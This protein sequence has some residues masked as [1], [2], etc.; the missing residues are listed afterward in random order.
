[1]QPLETTAPPLRPRGEKVVI[2]ASRAPQ[3]IGGVYLPDTAQKR[4]TEGVIVALPTNAANDLAIGQ[5]V[6]FL[7]WTGYFIGYEGE[8][9][10][11]VDQHDVLAI[12]DDPSV[13]IAFSGT[14]GPPIRVKG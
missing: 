7:R 9:Y 8:D 10:I 2:K 14:M 6:L 5:T 13:E 4:S 3:Q 1:M 12:L 11:L